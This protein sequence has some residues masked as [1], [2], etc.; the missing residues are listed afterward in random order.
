[1]GSCRDLWNCICI[2]GMAVGAELK[3]VP[4]GDHGVRVGHTELSLL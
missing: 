4:E 2:D 1:M 3:Q